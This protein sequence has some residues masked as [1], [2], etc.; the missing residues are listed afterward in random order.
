LDTVA[1]QVNA[2][3]LSVSVRKQ[4]VD[5]GGSSFLLDV[6]FEIP[7]GITILFGPSGAGKST[8][9]DCIAGLVRPDS[10]RLG[11]GDRALFDSDSGLDVPP[12][13]RQ[14]AYV[15][16]SLALFPHMTVRQNVAYGLAGLPEAARTA[17]ILEALRAFRVENLQ[18]RKP[19]HISGGEKQRVALARSL[20]T[21]P[22]VL[23]LDE[24]LTGLDDALKSSIIAD[25]RAW[26]AA[27]SI[28]I[29]YVTHSRDEIDALGER[30]IAIDQGRIIGEGTPRDVLDAPKRRSLAQ[31]A[32]FENLLDG[33][34]LELRESEG[35]MR[36]R[37]SDGPCEIEVPLAYAQP[38]NRVRIAVRAGDIL[39]ASEHPKALSARN[40][41][42]GRIVS[43]SR[44]GTMVI[45][46]VNCGT[47]FEVHIT[48]G[49]EHALQLTND[50]PVWL[51]LKTHSC[52]LV[53]D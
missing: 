5:A 46:R 13:Q 52:H 3:G 8:L 18:S 20:V 28:P 25:L 21:L 34:V 38:G 1:G 26:N 41:L 30:V 23:L 31:T 45:A 15:F 36:V 24:P 14:V 6:S 44:R 22:R 32:G 47:D 16:Q 17:R 29:L 51:V 19:I 2:A 50:K 39:L 35:V 4:Q 40:V 12:R 37:L 48:P 33:T 42:A 10:G 7:S 11:T 43:L 49:A 27:H 53:A 9:L